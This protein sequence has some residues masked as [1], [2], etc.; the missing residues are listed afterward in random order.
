MKMQAE[1]RA[2]CV[3]EPWPANYETTSTAQSTCTFAV[4]AEVGLRGRGRAR[5]TGTGRVPGR[6]GRDAGARRSAHR[7]SQMEDNSHE[8]AGMHRSRAQGG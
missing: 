1:L 8:V 6:D 4:K 3:S 5:G 7:D 2:G